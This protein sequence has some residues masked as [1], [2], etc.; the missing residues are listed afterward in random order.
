MYI[1]QNILPPQSTPDSGQLIFMVLFHLPGLSHMFQMEA[2]SNVSI[3]HLVEEISDVLMEEVGDN[4]TG[5]GADGEG[6]NGMGARF[7]VG[8]RTRVA[9]H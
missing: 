1:S 6:V 4:E 9:G 3:V 8:R 7:G 2:E 5:W